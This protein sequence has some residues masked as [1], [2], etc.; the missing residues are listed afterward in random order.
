MAHL[1]IYGPTSVYGKTGKSLARSA[2]ARR[3]ATIGT[4]EGM[5]NA[6]ASKQIRSGRQQRFRCGQYNALYGGKTS[7][8]RARSF[9]D[10]LKPRFNAMPAARVI[11]Q[12]QPAGPR[13]LP[14]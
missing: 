14:H 7:S 13:P 4:G 10:R 6:S 11:N 1:G 2:R 5:S 9:S 8:G 3:D 12:G